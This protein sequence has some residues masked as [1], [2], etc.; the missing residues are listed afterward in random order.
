VLT[1]ARVAN[2]P[3]LAAIS[4]RVG[5]WSSFKESMLARLSSA[6]YPALQPLRTRADDDFTV[7]L[8]DASA[9]MLDVLTFY[10]ERLANESYLRT[11]GQLRSLTELSRLIGYQ[12]APG[13]SAS[14]YLAF[15]FRPTPGQPPDPSA[16]P[17]TIPMGTQVQSVPAQDQTPQTFET[18]ADIQAKPDWSALQVQTGVPW[19]PPG[20]NSLY[21]SGTSTQLQPGDAML[22]L[23]V[24]RENWSGAQTPGEQWDVVVL[25]EVQSDKL[26]NLTYVRWSKRLRHWS[27]IFGPPP[28]WTTA[29][30]FAFRQKT[31]PFGHNAPDANLFTLASNPAATSLPNLIDVPTSGGPWQWRNFNIPSYTQIDLAATYSK[32]VTGS[33]FALV[34]DGWGMLAQL[35]RATNA[36][37]ASVAKYA[38]SAKVTELAADYNDSVIVNLPLRWTEVWAQSEQLD[39]PEQPLYYPLYGTAVQLE[40]RRTDMAAVQ[41]IA[42]AGMRQKI[43]VADGLLSPLKFQP[44]EGGQDKMLEPGEILTL[45][46]ILPL[47][48]NPDGSIP[49]WTGFPNSLTLSVQRADGRAGTVAAT[50]AGFRLVPPDKNDPIVRE[51]VQVTAV[52]TIA[53]PAGHR[54][55]TRFLLKSRLLNIYDRSTTTVNA[56]VGLATHGRSVSEILGSGNS[57]AQNQTFRLK[58]SPLTYVQG[59]TPTGRTS[60]LVLRVNGVEWRLKPNLFQQ[61]SADTV[62]ATADQPGGATDVVF[63]DGLEGALLPTGQ[64][65]VQASYRIGSGAAGNV[66]AGALTTLM[67]RPLGVSG[68]INPQPATGGQDAESLGDMRTNAPRT[69][70]TLGRAVSI[71][72]YQNFARSFAGIAKAHALW[73]PSGPGRGLFLTV[74]GAGGAALPP[75]SPTLATLAAALRAYGNPLIPITLA[76]FVETLFKFSAAI[77]Y[78]PAYDQPIVAAAV[79]RTLTAEFS[80]AGR[81]F[82]QGVGVDEIAALTQ[83]VPGVIGVNVTGLTRGISSTGGDLASLASFSTVTVLADWKAQQITLSRPFADSPDR[84]CAFLPVADFKALPQPAEILVLDPDPNAVLL[85]VLP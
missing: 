65:N 8:I 32:I 31:A 28:S 30:I 75:D 37:T 67:D 85:G 55:Y 66:G 33:W 40:E 15:S 50:L 68:V 42:L 1:P 48:L 24:E 23:G 83:D 19:A 79:R 60:T 74:A 76:S 9:I 59:A 3:G 39:V 53:D 56:N 18:A 5:T 64:N 84:L 21:L 72:D 81:S 27:D 10:Q 63:G 47:P 58:Q 35:Y 49:D 26:R 41:M 43:A 78:D 7:A 6:E 29:K 11:A 82:G 61:G 62:Y 14:A 71:A 45:I 51:C 77:A 2:P 70:L 17:I 36:T 22:I 80:F 20:G 54:Q 4:Y 46:D 52:D 44:S 57:S 73:I 12:P 13:V 34:F 16:P 69:V 25:D 38:L